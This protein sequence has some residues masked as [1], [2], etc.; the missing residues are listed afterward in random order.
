MARVTAKLVE[1]GIF[2][3]MPALQRGKDGPLRVIQTCIHILIQSDRSIFLK[4]IQYGKGESFG[5]HINTGD[6]TNDAQN[7]ATI[8]SVETQKVHSAVAY[9]TVDGV[10]G[11][12]KIVS[13]C[14]SR[15]HYPNLTLQGLS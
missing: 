5:C 15:Y 14:D 13:S 6:I 7:V 9:A 3:T 4:R 2:V 12:R 10:K 1:Q 8:G 11:E